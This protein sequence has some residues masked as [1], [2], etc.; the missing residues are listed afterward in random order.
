M[1][2]PEVHQIIPIKNKSYIQS[3]WIGICMPIVWLPKAMFICLIYPT[4]RAVFGGTWILLR[5][6]TV[7]P[8]MGITGFATGIDREMPRS[9]IRQ[10]NLA[11]LREFLE[12][13]EKEAKEGKN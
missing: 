3:L 8:F 6:F 12:A 9:I 4:I 7:L 5:T 11:E 1:W 2:F 13:E 10:V